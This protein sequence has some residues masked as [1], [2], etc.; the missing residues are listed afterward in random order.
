MLG[1]SLNE[2]ILVILLM[3]IFIKPK[4]IPSVVNVIAKFW[5]KI[6]NFIYEIQTQIQNI[7]DEIDETKNVTYESFHDKIEKVRLEIEKQE[8]LDL[9]DDIDKK[10]PKLKIEKAK[11][12]TKTK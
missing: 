7:T 12:R 6:K 10:T 5:K 9:Y 8:E 11:Q 4:D 1:I 3:V 2:L